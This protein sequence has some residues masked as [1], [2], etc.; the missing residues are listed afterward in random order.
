[1]I[2]PSQDYILKPGD[3]IYLLK[4][5]ESILDKSMSLELK[6][7][8]FSGQKSTKNLSS[9]S[10]QKY[11]SSLINERDS[12]TSETERTI[13]PGRKRLFKQHTAPN[14]TG[15]SHLSFDETWHENETEEEIKMSKRF[16]NLKKISIQSSNDSLRG[17]KNEI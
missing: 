5:G 3:I 10:V 4:P 9:N 11:N 13:S 2:N 8:E 15:L 6:S 14:K 12:A 1:M 7:E 16:K 17:S